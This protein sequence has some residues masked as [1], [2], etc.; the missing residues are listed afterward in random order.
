MIFIAASTLHTGRC[1]SSPTTTTFIFIPWQ[2]NSK[3]S[4]HS[5][6]HELKISLFT[7]FSFHLGTM[8]EWFSKLKSVNH[9]HFNDVAMKSYDFL[10][11][12]V[13]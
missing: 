12:T 9:Y 7:C 13:P 3:F 2:R 4:L 10:T 6:L 8:S 11:I 1:I 5:I